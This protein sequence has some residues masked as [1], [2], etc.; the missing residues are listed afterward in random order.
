ME[1]TH[2]SQ[3]EGGECGQGRQ[4][5]ENKVKK[6]SFKVHNMV[7]E[8]EMYSNKG[9]REIEGTQTEGVEHGSN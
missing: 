4:N 1:A 5:G 2:K 9:D 8:R 7:G 3:W 6:P